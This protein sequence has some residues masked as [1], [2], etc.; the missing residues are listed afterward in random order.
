MEAASYGESVIVI[1]GASSGVG[2]ATVREFCRRGPHRI[3]LL[4][5]GAQGLK[6][7][8]QEV[9]NSGSHAW[10][11][12]VDIADAGAVEQ[13]MEQIEQTLGPVD[14]LINAAMTTVF[15]QFQDITPQEFRRVT[16]VCYLGTVYATH[17]VLKY[18][19]GR[20][21]GTIIQ[22]GS[23]AAY[24][25]IP[26]ASAESGAKHALQGFCE[27]LREELH[28]QGY[29]LAVC[30][31]HLPSLNTPQYSWSHTLMSQS[32][33]PLAPIYQP[34]IAA[35]A[36][37][38]AAGDPSR[39]VYVGIST[40]G[41]LWA[42]RLIPGWVEWY[43]ARWGYK[44]QLFNGPPDPQ[45]PSNLWDAIEGDFGAHGAFEQHARPFGILQTLRMHKALALGVVLGMTALLGGW[46]KVHGRCL[47]QWQRSPAHSS[48]P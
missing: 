11:Y 16:E 1:T 4:A 10:C 18:M 2:R 45:R 19:L 40:L 22:V 47:L 42:H 14:I 8:A 48:T 5:R 13:I 17:A 28:Y 24:Q 29:A 27:S 23:L 6:A 32:R 39:E 41:A 21:R 33:R 36:I 38:R 35:R 7:T 3:A 20:N 15:G 31:V 43:L 9:E 12:S 37:V 34:E 30:M 26:L 44:G 46:L 25:G